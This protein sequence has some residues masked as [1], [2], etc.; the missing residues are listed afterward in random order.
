MI[1][2]KKTYAPAK[3]GWCGES[4]RWQLAPGHIISCVVCG[5]KGQVSVAQ[6]AMRCL[7]CN[8]NGKANA[9][10][11]CLKCAG[12]GWEQVKGEEI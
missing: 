6:P 1:R 9:A 7:Q 3:C 8:G 5:G 2:Q 11:A 10:S 4:G 12:T